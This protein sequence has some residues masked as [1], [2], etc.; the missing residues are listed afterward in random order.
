MAS[1][2]HDGEAEQRRVQ[3]RD[4]ATTAPRRHQ[5]RREDRHADRRRATRRGRRPRRPGSSPR[6][7]SGASAGRWSAPSAAR[8]AISLRRVIARDR[9]RLARLAQAMSS[10]QPAA[11]I[12][13]S[14]CRLVSPEQILLQRDDDGADACVRVGKFAARG[15]GD[16]VHVLLRP[17]DA[18][19]PAPG[20]RRRS[21]SASR[22]RRGLGRRELHRGPEVDPRDCGTTKPRGITPMMVRRA[23]FIIRSAPMTLRIGRSSAAA[24]GRR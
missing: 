17:L 7:P 20:A 13:T 6:S 19:R 5:R 1:E 21:G 15:A 12:R 2:S 11:A 4:A 14:S 10:T 3:A 16:I 24:T 9:S 23:P 8:T 18:S 22:A